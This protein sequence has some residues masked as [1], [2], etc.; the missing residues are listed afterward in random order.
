MWPT[1]LVGV[2]VLG[3]AGCSTTPGLTGDPRR[4]ES[5]TT[6]ATPLVQAQ[7]IRPL[8]GSWVGWYGARWSALSIRESGDSL[9]WSW[10]SPGTGDY[11]NHVRAAGT[12][13]VAGD[14]VS[15]V[16]RLTDGSTACDGGDP[17][18][19]F[20]LKWDGEVLRG[21]MTEPCKVPVHV[22]FTRSQIRAL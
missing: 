9:R 13:S 8:F 4:V 19:T 5:I 11:V 6:P 7:M 17:K 10:D 21:T 12:G 15:L 18:Y 16:G 14:Q 3:V 2:L 22:E 20:T 1:A